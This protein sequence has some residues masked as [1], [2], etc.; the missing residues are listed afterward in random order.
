MVLLSVMLISCGFHSFDP[1]GTPKPIKRIFIRSNQV[2]GQLIKILSIELRRFGIVTSDSKNAKV[3][4]MILNEHTSRDY[5]VSGSDNL[6][7]KY[8][9]T[10]RVT[11]QIIDN[12]GK[13]L[14]AA[15]NAVEMREIIIN[16]NQVLAAVHESSAIIR[17]MRHAVATQ[18]LQNL[19][20]KKTIETICHSKS[21]K[22]TKH[23]LV[24]T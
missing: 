18:I 10:H 19:V 13:Q 20:S 23:R 22:C 2:D 9:L 16:F 7:D 17:S 21:I 4:I 14:L 6:H 12:R 24:K 1:N 3:G 5:A 11:Y 8:W 15:R